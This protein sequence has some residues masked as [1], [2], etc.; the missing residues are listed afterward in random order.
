MITLDQL[1]DKAL[2]VRKYQSDLYYEFRRDKSTRTLD[3]QISTGTLTEAGYHALRSK[4]DFVDMVLHADYR[5]G[6][7]ALIFAVSVQK[8]VF[9]ASQIPEYKLVIDRYSEMTAAD[10]RDT[11]DRNGWTEY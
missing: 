3:G 6:L 10:V 9:R 7:D 8:M 11:M 2:E 5:I 4:M 1:V